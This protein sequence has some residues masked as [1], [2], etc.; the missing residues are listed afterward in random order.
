MKRRGFLKFL[1][2]APAAPLAAK[3]AA[4]IPAASPVVAPTLAAAAGG[5]LWTA[6]Y[7]LGASAEWTSPLEMRAELGDGSEE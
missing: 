7:S 6:A 3:A 5:V 1:G 4:F 2:L